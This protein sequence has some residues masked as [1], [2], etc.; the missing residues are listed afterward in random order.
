MSK[1]RSIS[2]SFWNDTWVE[3]LSA[4]E[5]LLFIY[6]L[7]ND[8]TNMLGVYEIS[9]KK[10]SFETGISKENIEKY[11]NNF[12]LK[13]KV[14]YKNNHV[15]LVNFLRHQ[16]F[17]E[18]MM[19]SAIDIYNGLPSEMKQLTQGIDLERNKKGF[20]SLCNGFQRLPKVEVEVEVEKE[21]ELELEVELE[22]KN[23]N[24]TKQNKI[25]NIYYSFDHLKITKDE[26][27]ILLKQYSE[28]QIMDI[29]EKIQNYKKNKNY[30]SLFFTA[31]N[32]LK[33]ESANTE[34]KTPT[35][36]QK[37]KIKYDVV[38]YQID[39]EE[40]KR[41]LREMYLKELNYRA[42][43]TVKLLQENVPY[44]D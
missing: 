40:P 3:E 18:N 15:V 28:S 10:M 17:N 2:T 35:S 34:N 8:K 7:T 32:W 11:L 16:N 26:H 38:I 31:K 24:E 12:S 9:I 37:G 42:E 20:E 27:E 44:G 41:G 19:K 39:G 4:N 21:V 13:N 1:L 6:L 29:Y 30:T 23:E 5:K 22:S 36:Q 33:K 43:G 25:E 14:L